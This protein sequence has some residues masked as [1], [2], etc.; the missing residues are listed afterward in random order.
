MGYNT[1]MT[2][3]T[4]D[5]EQIALAAQ[6]LKSAEPMLYLRVLFPDAG[7]LD[8]I[9]KGN[10]KVSADQVLGACLSDPEWIRTIVGV[11][12]EHPAARTTNTDAVACE[13]AAAVILHSDQLSRG[14]VFSSEE[15]EQAEKTIAKREP[16]AWRRWVRAR[17]D[18][19]RQEDLEYRLRDE[20]LVREILYELPIFSNTERL[21]HLPL[22]LY[23]DL[24]FRAR[25]T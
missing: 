21:S 3:I 7:K 22:F 20:L 19:E 23:A 1:P 11:L 17:A 4:F 2:A 24:A 15:I 12:R 18:K 5:F 14:R 10:R 6:M 25:S 13:L 9:I 16:L 8:K